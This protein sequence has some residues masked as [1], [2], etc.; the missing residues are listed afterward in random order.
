MSD[1]LNSVLKNTYGNFSLDTQTNIF[2]NEKE[3]EEEQNNLELENTDNILN[4]NIITYGQMK[5]D[6]SVIEAAKRFARDRNNVKDEL[7]DE[8]AVKNFISH[9][10]SFNVNELTAGGDWNYISG[11]SADSKRDDTINTTERDLSDIAEQKA[12]KKINEEILAAIEKDLGDAL[13]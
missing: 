3:K 8:E 12:L 11:V 13:G 10:R 6:T 5:R 2:D 1:L 4:S 9:F 7:T